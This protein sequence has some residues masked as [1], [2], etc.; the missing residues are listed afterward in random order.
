MTAELS[1]HPE[2][3]ENG[4]ADILGAAIHD[5]DEHGFTA[6]SI[7]QIADRA[8]TSRSLIS[9]Y[10]PTK[11]SLAVAV[12]NLAYPA[13]VFMG[14]EREAQDPLEAIDQ[15]AEHLATS[16]AHGELARTAL[17]LH[18]STELQEEDLPMRHSGWLART[19]DYLE[20]ARCAKRIPAY[21]DVDAE[22]RI[23]VAGI[24]GLIDLAATSNDYLLL[25]DDVLAFVRERL[26][27]LI[28]LPAGP[29]NTL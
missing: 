27:A 26:A 13:G 14:R 24:F 19:T 1:N 22:C 11:T 4:A 12:I 2:E 10:F 5:F 17:R 9:Y 25:V 23:M 8:G 7:S 3:A 18:S 6:S 20:E 15:A 16:V 21:V 29:P 28:A